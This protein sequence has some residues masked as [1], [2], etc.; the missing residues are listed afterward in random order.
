MIGWQLFA[1]FIPL[2]AMYIW[3]ASRI[4]K[5]EKRVFTLEM[6]LHEASDRA[7]RSQLLGQ[8][9]QVLADDD[10]AREAEG[11]PPFSRQ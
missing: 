8:I 5:L 9:T 3:L 7:T 1:C 11:L 6:Q 10:E 4:D 2:L